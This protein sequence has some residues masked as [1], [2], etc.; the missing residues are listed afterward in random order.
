MLAVIFLAVL[1]IATLMGPI[2]TLSSIKKMNK[3]ELGLLLRQND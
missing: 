3:D 1:V 2:S